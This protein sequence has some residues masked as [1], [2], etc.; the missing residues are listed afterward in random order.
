MS[1]EPKVIEQLQIIVSAGNEYY[2][3][4]FREADG[5]G[6]QEYLNAFTNALNVAGFTYLRGLTRITDSDVENI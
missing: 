5:A 1:Y 6:L 3:A 2:H 4:T